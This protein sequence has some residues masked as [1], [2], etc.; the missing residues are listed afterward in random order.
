M[1][2]SHFRILFLLSLPH[3]ISS[4]SFLY[5]HSCCHQSNV[6][7]E[8]SKLWG[9]GFLIYVKRSSHIRLILLPSF[10][11]IFYTSGYPLCSASTS[12]YFLSVTGS[13]YAYSILSLLSLRRKDPISQY[14][15]LFSCQHFFFSMYYPHFTRP[16]VCSPF[17]GFLVCLFQFVHMREAAISD[18]VR[19]FLPPSSISHG[20]TFLAILTP[21]T[22]CN[23]VCFVLWPLDV[24]VPVFA[25]ERGFH[26]DYCCSLPPSLSFLSCICISVYSR[27]TMCLVLCAQRSVFL[28]T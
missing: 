21:Y 27:L 6:S 28:A 3:S 8:C 25:C 12:R 14:L 5:L 15:F 22:V 10:P 11:L 17:R 13:W 1:R 4:F 9:S 26:L 24:F 23:A 18:T 7:V 2:V 16:V 20:P 19:T